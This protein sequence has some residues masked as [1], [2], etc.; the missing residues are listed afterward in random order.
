MA[1][2]HFEMMK[3]A[4][5]ALDDQYKAR[6]AI[7]REGW[8]FEPPKDGSMWLKFDY[9]EADTR[10]LS[11]DRKCKSYIGLVQISIIFP[12]NTGTDNARRLAKEIAEF[13]DDG[14][15]LATGYIFEGAIVHPIQKSETGWFIPVRYQLRLDT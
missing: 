10:W 3:A 14:K 15:I 12:P 4:R 7:S 6:F 9:M 5:Q 11:L 8:P 2:D 1:F 13:F